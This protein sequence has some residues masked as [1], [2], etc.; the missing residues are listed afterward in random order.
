[1]MGPRI[2]RIDWDDRH[3]LEACISALRS[4]DPNTAVGACI[5][6]PNN[7]IVAS[8]Y[9]AFPNNISTSQLPWDREAESPYDTKYAYVVHAE[10]NAIYNATGPVEGCTLY[11]TL[12]P[13]NQC[14]QDIIQAGISKIVYLEDKYAET[15]QVKASKRMATLLDLEYTQHVWDPQINLTLERLKDIMLLCDTKISKDNSSD[16]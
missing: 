11:V 5:V 16:S 7:R 15:W 4:P 1:M 12:F 2:D 3:M 14:M 13:C 8:G 10:K 9:N 6:N